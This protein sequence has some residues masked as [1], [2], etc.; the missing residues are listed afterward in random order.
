M[1]RSPPDQWDRRTDVVVIGS[2]TGL[3][4]ALVAAEAGAAVRLLQKAPVVGETTAV[5]GGG[6]WVPNSRAVVESA[7]KSPGEELVGYL[8]WNSGR[9]TAR[10]K[11]E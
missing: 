4:A 9:P 11:L 6:S 2:G 8:N 5:S 3:A 10:A 7:G 1:F